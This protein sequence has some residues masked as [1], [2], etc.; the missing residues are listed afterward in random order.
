MT[1]KWPE[2]PIRRVRVSHRLSMGGER[3]DTRN[4][5]SKLMLTILAGV[6][7]WERGD[8]AR[9]S[10]REGIAKAKAEGKYRGCKPHWHWPRRRRISLSPFQLA[11]RVD[12]I[13]IDFRP[14]PQA[15][16]VNNFAGPF[17]CDPK[18]LIAL[19]ARDLRLMDPKPLCQFS[20]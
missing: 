9:T 1:S 17:E 2:N 15:E 14:Y 11:E 20:L 19:V 16:R 6:A 7:R 10:Q 8:H 4:P 12:G 5:T 13:H 18:I 3:L